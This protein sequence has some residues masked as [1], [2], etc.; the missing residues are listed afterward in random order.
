MGTISQK[1]L[2]VFR[3]SLYTSKLGGESDISVSISSRTLPS[4]IGGR[5]DRGSGAR[6]KRRGDNCGIGIFREARTAAGDMRL[7]PI[8]EAS[9]LELVVSA[10]VL[11]VESPVTS[12]GQVEP[13]VE[14]D[15]GGR[16]LYV[17]AALR[18]NDGTPVRSVESWM[19]YRA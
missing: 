16:L 1:F 7:E 5:A 2:L 10:A 3:T 9:E 12:Y 17:W 19:T 4:L 6:R 8:V 13:V 18:A 14:S 15:W 11:V